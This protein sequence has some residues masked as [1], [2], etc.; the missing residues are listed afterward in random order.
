MNL[1]DRFIVPKYCN[2]YI[3]I[4]MRR[5]G[6]F[7]N[8]IMQIL[9]IHTLKNYEWTEKLREKMKVKQLLLLC[10]DTGE[11]EIKTKKENRS[12][13]ATDKDNVFNEKIIVMFFLAS[14]FIKALL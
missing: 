8:N 4:S 9:Q 14:I 6:I 5:Q 1:I 2:K 13:I 7:S 3:N 11:T 10:E 12:M